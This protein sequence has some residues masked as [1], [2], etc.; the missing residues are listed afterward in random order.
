MTS[1]SNLLRLASAAVLFAGVSAAYASASSMSSMSY[2]GTLTADDQ[3]ISEPFSLMSAAPVTV[4]T[5]SYG[6]GTNADGTTVPAGGFVPLLTIFSSDG[7]LVAQNG[8]NGMCEGAAV[9]DP[10]TKLCNDAFIQAMLGAGS[11]TIDVSEFPNAANGP[12][13]SDGFLF[14][15]SPDITGSFCGTST[16]FNETDVAP[17]VQR[18]GNYSLS[19]SVS[20]VPEPSSMFLFGVGLASVGLLARR[21]RAQSV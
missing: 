3:V 7:A 4:W 9:A 19:Y 6:G 18:T 15:G 14:A 8:A 12:K 16:M 1:G 11:Y 20:S 13:M 21:K 17:C 10:T 2:T 5:D